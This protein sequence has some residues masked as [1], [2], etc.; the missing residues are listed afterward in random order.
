MSMILHFECARAQSNTDGVKLNIILHPVQTITINSSH[1][2]V[3]LQYLNIE[4]YNKGVS[5][6]LDDHLTVTSTG[7]FQVNIY[8]KQENFTLAGA[9]ESIPVS[10][11][12]ITAINGSDNDLTPIF[13]NVILSTKPESLIRSGIGGI[14]LK[15]TVTYD[16]TGVGAVGKYADLNLGNTEAIFSTEITYTITSK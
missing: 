15:Y 16:N 6:T 4:D 1:N 11:V 14:N 3:E 2:N 5:T 8:S 13:D 7:G 9:T 10:D 12:V